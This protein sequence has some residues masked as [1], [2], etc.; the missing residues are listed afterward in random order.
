MLEQIKAVRDYLHD[1]GQVIRQA[2]VAFS[3]GCLLVAAAVFTVLVRHFSGQIDTQRDTIENQRNRIDQLQ[4]ELKGVSP[5]LA[6]LQARRTKARE[7]LLELYVAAAPLIG[8]ELP[9]EIYS[10]EQALDNLE[11]EIRGWET[12][13]ANWIK[14]NVAIAAESRFLDIS[15]MPIYG[16]GGGPRYDRMMN[17]LANERKNL[18]LLIETAAYDK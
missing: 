13:T 2:P 12:S 18:A 1:E 10:N 6:A 14:D 17:K 4:E 7:K 8:K 11:S 15:N 9:K 16:W 3:V 5:Q